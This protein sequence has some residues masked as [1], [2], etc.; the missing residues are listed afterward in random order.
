MTKTTI[1]VIKA[2]VG[3]VSGHGVAHPALMDICADSL[4]NAQDSGL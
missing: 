1:S 4:I 3:S 2:D